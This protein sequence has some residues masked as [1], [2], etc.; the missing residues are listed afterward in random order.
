MKII[1]LLISL[2]AV[3]VSCGESESLTS[4]DT[5]NS[6]VLDSIE[7][8]VQGEILEKSLDY[9]QDWDRFKRAAK[10]KDRNE[11]ALLSTEQINDFEG[12]SFLLSELHVMRGLDETSFDDLEL[13]EMDGKSYLQFSAE[14][15][16]MDEEGYEVGTSLTLLFLKTAEGLRL[17][18]YLAAG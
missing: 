7:T 3:A 8:E 18:Q 1:A 15:I 9:G 2:L 12:L 17:D 5:S 16:G 6:A 4:P 10:S 14:E 11:L 13:V